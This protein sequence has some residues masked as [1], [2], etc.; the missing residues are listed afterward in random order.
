MIDQDVEDCGCDAAQLSGWAERFRYYRHPPN[1]GEISSWLLRFGKKDRDVACRMLDH[2]E[3]VSEIEI[4]KAY[5]S[6]ASKIPGWS[7]IKKNNGSRT[8]IVGFGKA[9]ES[10][11]A[12]VRLFREANGLSNKKFDHLFCAAS[13]LPGKLLTAFDN[14][15]F[16][17]DFSGSGKQIQEVWPVLEEL[18]ASEA[19][20][21]LILTAMTTVAKN[22]VSKIKRLKI[23]VGKVIKNNKNIFDAGCDIFSSK[24][25]ERILAYC[26]IADKR[27]PKGFGECGLLY[28]LSHK[29]PNNSIPILHAN[30]AKWIG[31]FPRYLNV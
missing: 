13:E 28:V 21:Y 9:G 25:K 11:D 17:D 2:V 15:I 19:K 22:R 10:G 23:V 6:C 14:V 26:R 8:F 1:S 18:I 16:V 24:E 20:C 4:Q 31:L 29:T 12:M 30:H 7:S 5:K 3:V 27:N